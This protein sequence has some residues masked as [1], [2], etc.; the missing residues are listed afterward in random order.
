MTTFKKILAATMMAVAGAGISTTAIAATLT[1]TA[2]SVYRLH[3]GPLPVWGAE[4]N[5]FNCSAVAVSDHQLV[6]AAHCIP[7]DYQTK[8]L[9]IVLTE[10]DRTQILQQTILPFKVLRLNRSEDTAF[11][12]LH[13]KTYKLPN[14]VDVAA[15]YSPKLGDPVYALGYPRGDVLTLTEGMYT[16]TV[17]LE[18]ESR[19]QWKGDYYKTTV[20]ISGGS[21]GGGLFTREWNPEIKDWDYTLI[22]LATAGYRDVSFQNYFS[23]LEALHRTLRGFTMET[24]I[25]YTNTDVKSYTEK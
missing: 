8:T 17:P 23:T 10:N 25:D 24:S 20:P 2:A 3:L 9:S 21:S 4:A 7:F 1:D 5:A 11:I 6:T 14:W 16:A 18:R 22:G 19:G 15:E 13:S 12:E